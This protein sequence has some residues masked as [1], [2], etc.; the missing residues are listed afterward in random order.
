MALIK[1]LKNTIGKLFEKTPDGKS[2]PHLMTFLAGAGLFPLF[3]MLAVQLGY[4]QGNNPR[5]SFVSNLFT[6]FT[7]LT[8]FKPLFDKAAEF[9]GRYTYMIVLVY[10]AIVFSVY[11]NNERYKRRD[12]NAKGREHWND[13]K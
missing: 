9:N 1:L 2:N 8:N 5:D 10:A 6:A 13:W 3:T 12:A 4:A 11:I 7:N